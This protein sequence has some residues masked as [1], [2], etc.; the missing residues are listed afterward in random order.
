MNRVFMSLIVS[1]ALMS[2]VANERALIT[3][4]YPNIFSTAKEIPFRDTI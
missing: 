1:G 3:D 4:D 2:G